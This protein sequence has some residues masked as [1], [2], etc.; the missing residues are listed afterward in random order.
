VQTMV[1]LLTALLFFGGC[2]KNPAVASAPELLFEMQWPTEV[3]QRSPSSVRVTA[4]PPGPGGSTLPMLGI[5]VV[6]FRMS[7]PAERQ[8]ALLHPAL[9]ESQEILALVPRA[10]VADPARPGTYFGALTC[11]GTA[12]AHL[13]ALVLSR[14]PRM[15]LRE[16]AEYPIPADFGPVRSETNLLLAPLH[17]ADPLPPGAAAEGMVCTA[18][19]EGG[20]QFTLELAFAAAQAG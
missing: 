5:P 6:P 2:V 16:V 14:E 7:T 18:P 19:L 11:Q 4:A 10:H 3:E 15:D 17:S 13:Q 20:G 1:L 9:A 8:E 12:A